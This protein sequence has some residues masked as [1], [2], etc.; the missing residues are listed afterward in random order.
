MPRTE[1]VELTVL[2]LVHN[3]DCYLLQNRVKEDWQGFTFPG[4]HIEAGESIVDAVVREMKEETGLTIF[5]P[6]LCGVKQFPIENG[7]YIVFLFRTDEYEGELAS[8]DEGTMHWIP[9]E[10]LPK[11]NIVDDFNDLMR[12]IMDDSLCEFQYVLENDSWHIVLK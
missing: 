6:R 5:H 10:D 9:K 11:I 2:C 1:N 7:R 4:G 8:S 12:V 3:K